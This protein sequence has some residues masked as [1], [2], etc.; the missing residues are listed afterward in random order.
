MIGYGSQGFAHS[1]N[2]RDSGVDVVVALR[3]ESASVKKAQE[4]GLKVMTNREA[5][6]WTDVIMVLVPDHL[7][8]EVY[9]KDIAPSLSAGKTVMF[10]HGFNIHFGQIKPPADVDVSMVAP[11]GPGHTVTPPVRA[12]LRGPLP[13]SDKQRCQRQGTGDRPGVCSGDRRSQSRGHRDHL[14]GRDGDR[15]V[16]RTS[17]SVRRGD[18]S[19][20]GGGQV[21]FDDALDRKKP[22]GGQGKELGFYPQFSKIMISTRRFCRLPRSVLFSARGSRCPIPRV[23]TWIARSAPKDNR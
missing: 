5:S 10:A 22:S 11:K 17:G 3:K 18:S 7:Q 20:A 6:E 2:L 8:G 12:R 9:E 16:R 23:V 4:A 21:A 14:Q 15:P 19:N 1:N 13:D